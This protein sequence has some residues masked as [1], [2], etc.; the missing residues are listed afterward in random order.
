LTED[1]YDAVMQALASFAAEEMEFLEK[2]W[3]IENQ[4]RL[5][6]QIRGLVDVIL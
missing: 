3:C 4:D 6:I 2:G 5:E 1:E